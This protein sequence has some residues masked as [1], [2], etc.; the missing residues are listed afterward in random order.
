[1]ND[2]F[3]RVLRSCR[4]AGLDNTLSLVLPPPGYLP[5]PP[6]GVKEIGGP[7]SGADYWIAQIGGPLGFLEP[8]K[9][10]IAA[11][12]G[13]WGAEVDIEPLREKITQA[14]K[15]AEAGERSP[16]TLARY[17][18]QIDSIANAIR[19]LQGGTPGRLVRD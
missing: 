11:Y 8:M 3:F 9:K 16:E 19:A 12:I 6:P 10:A 7:S 13:D 15:A 2:D 4:R 14:F 5:S 17:L 1:M 18:A